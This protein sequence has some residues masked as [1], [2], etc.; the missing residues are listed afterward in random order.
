MCTAGITGKVATTMVPVVFSVS[1]DPVKTGPV[2]SLNR[3]GEI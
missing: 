2:A 1:G 3:P